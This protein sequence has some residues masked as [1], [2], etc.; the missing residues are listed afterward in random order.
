LQYFNPKHKTQLIADAS[1]VALGAVLLQF[2]GDDEPKIISFVSPSLTD[3]EKRCSQTE[4]ESLSIVW[5][6]EK[7]FYYLAKLEFELITDY[8]PLET[9]F[10]P[11]SKPP[12]RIKRWLLRLQAFKLIVK[13]KNG[14]KNIAYTFSRLC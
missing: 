1:P 9:I 14:K 7:F 11:S 10:K 6:V 3:V 4:K 12:A 13:Y 5:A 8:K 2:H